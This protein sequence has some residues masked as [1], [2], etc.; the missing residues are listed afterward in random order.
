[1]STEKL[2]ITMAQLYSEHSTLQFLLWGVYGKLY[3]RHLKVNHSLTDGTYC[4]DIE[5]KPITEE[6]TRELYKG[7]MDV[8]NSDTPIELIEVSRD[9]LIKR[10]TELKFKDKIGLLKT[11]QD[12]KIP[13]I[14]CGDFL[15][16]TIQRMTTDKERLKIFEIRPYDQGLVIRYPLISD[17]HK[18]P[19][20][21]DPKVL[22]HMFDEYAQWAELLDIEYV[23]KLNSRIYKR[24]IDSVKWV[25]EGLHSKKF[26]LMA[27]KL[28]ENFK[29]KRVITIA[30]PSSSNKTTFALRL[31]ISLRVN[32]YESLVIGM[33]D[34][35]KDR[36]DIPVG[37]NG[38]QDFE[39]IT[40]LNIPLLSQ[41]VKALL[42]GESV[43]SRRF[44]FVKGVG[45]D[46][47]KEQ[48]KLQKNS[49]LIIEGIHGLNPNLLEG[50]GR[51]NVTPIYV[52]ALTPVSL[53][54]NH[55]FSTSD[56]RLIR[57][58]IRD[59]RFRGYSPRSTLRRWPSVRRGEVK[60]IFP[61]QENA[62]MFFNS[63]LIYEL[64]VLMIFG[65]GLLAEATLPEKG[66]D[67]NTPEAKL[68]SQEARRLLGLI[69]FFYPVS[70]EV[71]PHTSLIREF[72]GGSDFQY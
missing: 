31:Q 32:G 28:T 21:K 13:C 23:S 58:M 67:P 52:S 29:N 45:Y 65:K 8:L 37:P 63:S 36:K 42:N 30:G 48:M 62:E 11:W 68:I 54:S 6:M 69:N 9:E 27:D 19:E 22:H 55:R 43:P 17:P 64:P 26:T 53:D 66:E 7:I 57:R 51:Q 4:S 71:V 20:W 1:M 60:N 16:Y 12:E 61:Y 33:D 5:N 41:R 34:Y 25:A 56:L 72:V 46:N 47:E 3:N 40:A 50:L 2:E 14:K 15:D 24:K 49:F 18:I 59:Y 35:Y 10:F 44:D 70:V 39:V 38:E